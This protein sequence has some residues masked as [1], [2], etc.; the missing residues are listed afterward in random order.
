VIF[1]S[2]LKPNA[3]GLKPV[4]F[5]IE[6]FIVL[7]DGQLTG[8]TACRMVQLKGAASSLKRVCRE[9]EGWIEGRGWG[10]RQGEED[11]EEIKDWVADA[12]I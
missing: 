8:L 7:R 1:C 12:L 5:S 11:V 2:L 6:L 3:L 4:S 9:L 10:I